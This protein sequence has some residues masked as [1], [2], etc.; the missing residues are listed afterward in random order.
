MT[1]ITPLPGALGII[2]AL[3]RAIR[4]CRMMLELPYT[5][6]DYH[7]DVQVNETNCDAVFG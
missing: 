3:K 2:A 7:R 5:T 4:M 6:W 1:D